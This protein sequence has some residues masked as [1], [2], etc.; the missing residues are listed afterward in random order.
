MLQNLTR[1]GKY[2]G[3]RQRQW[4]INY[5]AQ[6]LSSAPSTLISTYSVIW[7]NSVTSCDSALHSIVSSI[8]SILC[9]L[10]LSTLVRTSVS[11]S[12][13]FFNPKFKKL[14]VHSP[15]STV[16]SP[17]STQCTLSIIYRRNWYTHIMIAGKQQFCLMWYWATTYCNADSYSNYVSVHSNFF[18]SWNSRYPQGLNK[19]ENNCNDTECNYLRSKTEALIMFHA[20]RCNT[21]HHIHDNGCGKLE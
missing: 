16:H 12:C 13:V 1:V 11:A 21:R 9:S 10:V 20:I 8:K 3:Y 17:Q 19:K 14:Q 4:K 6:L 5:T 2:D 18:L 7:F 15:Q